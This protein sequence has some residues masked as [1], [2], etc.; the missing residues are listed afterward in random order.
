MNT[1]E[2]FAFVCGWSSTIVWS[3]SYYPQVIENYKRKCAIGF[4]FDYLAYNIT[5]QLCYA[6]Y[7]SLL[8]W[9]P[10]VRRQYHDA[11]GSGSIP[12]E[13]NDV[14]FSIHAVILVAF[15]I[16]QCFIYERGD[17]KVSKTC[18][19]QS[20]VVWLYIVV[21]VS[22]GL[23][24]VITYY[25]ILVLISFV[26]IWSSFVKYTPQAYLNWVRKS[27]VGWNIVNVLLDFAGGVLSIMQ[28]VFLAIDQDDSNQITG[29]PA[30]LGLGLE[31]LLFDAIF[32]FQHYVLYTNRRDVDA[33]VAED[34]CPSH[35]MGTLDDVEEAHLLP[36]QKVGD[37]DDGKDV[38]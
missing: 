9:N 21:A 16:F 32:I 11:H 2:W 33:K 26:K 4:S 29:N 17:Q 23:A 19:T 12:V 24:G 37:D 7:N 28:M 35:L 13:L 1:F 31:S 5:G 30:K 14:I 8:Y 20:A 34:T 10:T 22:L 18:K 38:V 6:T 36:P 25:Q 3:I 27:T 15:L